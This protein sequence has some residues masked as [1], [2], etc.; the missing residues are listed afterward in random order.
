MTETFMSHTRELAQAVTP[1]IECAARERLRDAGVGLAHE[2]NGLEH[3][4][5]NLRILGAVAAVALVLPLVT[6]DSSFAQSPPSPAGAGGARA[7]GAPAGGGGFRG[8][9]GGGGF[10]GGGG[11]GAGFRAGGGAGTAIA[12][13]SG[14]G[15]RSGGGY[16]GGGGYAYRG[17]GYRGGYYRGGGGFIPGAV[18]GAV[19]GGA[20]ASSAYPYGYGYYGAPAYYDDQYYDDGAVAVAPAP[21]A[22]DAAYCAQRFRSYDPASGTYLGNDG[23]RHPCP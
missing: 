11:G 21:G 19:I 22:D 13:P 7:G 15:F 2:F 18:A 14:G 23:L 1:H 3:M 20:I 6:P 17:G 9:G 4:M 10:R 8:G 16:R 5:I 12:P